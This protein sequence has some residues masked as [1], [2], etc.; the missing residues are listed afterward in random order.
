MT[1]ATGIAIALLTPFWCLG[2]FILAW[3][4]D[5]SPPLRPRVSRLFD[6]LERTRAESPT[7]PA[8][9]APQPHDRSAHAC[10]TIASTAASSRDQRRIN[11]FGRSTVSQEPDPQLAPVCRSR[12]DR[13]L[14]T[15]AVV[16]PLLLVR[17]RSRTASSR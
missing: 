2:L 6:W 12:A 15:Q 3:F 5:V 10:F 13:R 14:V 17:R 9:H 11:W 1:T 7:E 8:I 4:G 16:G